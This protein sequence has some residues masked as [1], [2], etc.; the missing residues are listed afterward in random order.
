[1]IRMIRAAFMRSRCRL[2]LGTL[3]HRR[4]HHAQH[5]TNLTIKTLLTPENPA[6]TGQGHKQTATAFPAT[7]G[8]TDST[9]PWRHVQQQANSKN[10]HLAVKL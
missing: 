6:A 7:T 2:C 5:T 8:A 3:P 4:F 1:M 9:P 10:S